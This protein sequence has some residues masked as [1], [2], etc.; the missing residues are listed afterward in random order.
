MAKLK[1]KNLKGQLRMLCVSPQ[2]N[3]VFP[4]SVSSLTAL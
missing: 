2:G 4:F 1:F 3:T